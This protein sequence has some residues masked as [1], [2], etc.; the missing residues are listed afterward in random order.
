MKIFEFYFNPPLKEKEKLEADA[1]SESF[2]F[3]PKNVYEKK[4]GSLYIVG[5][6]KN[7]LPANLDFLTKLAFFIK[8]KYYKRTVLTPERSLRKTLKETNEFLEKIAAKGDVSWLGNLNFAVLA[9]KDYKIHFTKVGSMKMMLLRAGKLVDIEKKINLQDIEPYPLKIFGNIISGKLMED[10]LLL[11]FTQDIFDFFEEEAVIEKII[12]RPTDVD[13]IVK[14]IAEEKKEQ[15]KKRQGILLAISLIKESAPGTKEI[16]APQLKKYFSVKEVFNFYFQT[17]KQ[18]LS[19]RI[20]AKFGF[21][22]K[23]KLGKKSFLVLGF[24]F[25][26]L[27]GYL[28]SEIDLR[29]KTKIYLSQLEEVEKTLEKIEKN[30][31]NEDLA[32]IKL[33]KNFETILPIKK[34]ASRLKKDFS[35]KVLAL[36]EKIENRL[37]LLYKVEK[38]N[39]PEV[40]FQFDFRKFAPQKIVF[41]DGEL[42]FI[43]PYSKNIF[44]IDKKKIG[45]ILET[46]KNFNLTCAINDSLLFFTKPNQITILTDNKFSI[47]YLKAPYSNSNFADLFCKERS[48]YF[49]DKSLGQIVQYYL[50][51]PDENY[52][53]GDP[54]LLLEKAREANAITFDENLW[55]LDKKSIL[56]FKEGQLKEEIKPDIFPDAESFS[57]IYT[58]SSLPYLF[59]LEPAKKRILILEKSG[60]VF[61]Q[62]F[63]EKFN[64]LLDFAVSEDGKTIFILNGLTLYKIQI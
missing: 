19:L 29:K 7:V 10:D 20:F 2:C 56:K 13:E 55:L 8:D 41:L 47:L 33:R 38:I 9:L 39:D 46:D 12:Q 14:N 22:T 53:L 24:L 61:K 25:F 31:I 32:K 4:M 43:T 36:N 48:L 3:E 28:I 5:N 44:R 18:F 50:L 52:K 60:K 62:I 23:I 58:T 57:K 11:V 37:F 30:Q 45:T 16:I 49:L 6:L 54:E 26:L 17:I 42:Y 35:E 40:Y 51:K 15:L 59:V 64:S 34:D 63:S 21:L 27:L 1:I